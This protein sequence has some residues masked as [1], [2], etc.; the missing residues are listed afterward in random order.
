M[1]LTGEW[2]TTDAWAGGT[3]KVDL[4]GHVVVE[5]H[6]VEPDDTYRRRVILRWSP[7]TKAWTVSRC[8]WKRDPQWNGSQPGAQSN[9]PFGS[10]E[11]RWT[12]W[13]WLQNGTGPL[14]EN[15]RRWMVVSPGYG[16]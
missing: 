15:I 8:W 10:P 13:E 16:D 7:D 3:T 2:A 12:L 5:Y 1:D 14:G 9:V 6:P 4:D 11:E